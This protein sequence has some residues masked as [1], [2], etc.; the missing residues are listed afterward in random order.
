MGI[1]IIIEININGKGLMSPDDLFYG[2]HGTSDRWN[3]VNKVVS[4][5]PT[6]NKTLNKTAWRTNE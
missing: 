1:F 5:G 3:M 4:L 6:G 2:S